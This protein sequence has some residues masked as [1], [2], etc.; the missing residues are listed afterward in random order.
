M[1]ETI[2]LRQVPETATLHRAPW[3]GRMMSAFVVTA[4]LGP[5]IR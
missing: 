2:N 4:L 3:A 1:A 5:L